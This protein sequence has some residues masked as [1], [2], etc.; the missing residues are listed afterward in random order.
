MNITTYRPKPEVPSK[1]HKIVL[2]HG[3]NTVLVGWKGK[4]AEVLGGRAGF[5]LGDIAKGQVVS[6]FWTVEEGVA[7][8][9]FTP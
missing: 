3:Y 8:A 2:Y 7:N 6:G 9:R 5:V 4:K 1:F